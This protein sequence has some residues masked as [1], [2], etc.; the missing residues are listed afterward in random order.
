M[1]TNLIDSIKKRIEGAEMGKEAYEYGT[2]LSNANGT[3]KTP[4]HFGR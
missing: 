4:D 3:A 2:I 1:T